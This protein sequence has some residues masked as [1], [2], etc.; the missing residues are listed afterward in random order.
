MSERIFVIDGFGQALVEV[1][2]QP[3]GVVSCYAED[4]F[5]FQIDPANR[6]KFAAIL[7][8]G[9]EQECEKH[10]WIDIRNRYVLSGSLCRKCGAMADQNFDQNP[11]AREGMKLNIANIP[12]V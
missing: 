9:L 5:S 4:L 12:Q 10:D 7:L 3:N 8:E 1:D 11:V 2:H 6:R